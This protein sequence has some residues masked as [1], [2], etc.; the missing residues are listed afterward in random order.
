MTTD[1]PSHIAGVRTAVPGAGDRSDNVNPAT[2]AVLG[3]IH[4]ATLDDV[5]AAVAAARAAQ[6]AWAALT[7]TE[8][9]RILKRTA[10]ILRRD[11]EALARLEV[12]DTGKP[13]AEALAVDVS[14]AADCLEFF[15]GLAAPVQGEHIPLGDAAFAYTRREPL[16][17]CAGI[18][19]WNYPLQIAAWKAAPALA[20]GN[21]M[22]FKPSD[23][24]PATAL[25]LADA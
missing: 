15:G 5:A 19:A 1:Y 14:S 24:T 4:H 11:T 17:V 2:G 25:A 9:G 13:I 20:M 3:T 8:R 21:A 18:G 16:G 22:I 23:M 6:P 7:G 10:D 12:L